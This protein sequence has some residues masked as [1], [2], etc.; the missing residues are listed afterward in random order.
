MSVLTRYATTRDAVKIAFTV[1]GNGPL[2]IFVGGPGGPPFELWIELEAGRRH[3]EERRLDRRIVNFDFRGT[4]LSGQ[5]HSPITIEHLA[6]DIEAVIEAAAD[7][8]PTKRVDLEAGYSG[9]AP[10]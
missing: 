2:A 3:A 1:S 6:W 10:A 9:V 4:G 8:N 7:G 5:L